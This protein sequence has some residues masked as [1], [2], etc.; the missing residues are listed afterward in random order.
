MAKCYKQDKLVERVRGWGSL[1]S[2]TVKYGDT[3][4]T[5]LVRTSSNCK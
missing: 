3:R 5:A 2:E 4:I 1:K